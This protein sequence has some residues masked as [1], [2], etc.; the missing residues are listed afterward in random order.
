M[1]NPNNPNNNKPLINGRPADDRRTTSRAPSGPGQQLGGEASASNPQEAAEQRARESNLQRQKRLEERA[2][3]ERIEKE[4]AAREEAER[5]AKRAKAAEAAQKKRIEEAVE[6]RRQVRDSWDKSPSR[7]RS[8]QPPPP[9]AGIHERMAEEANRRVPVKKRTEKKPTSPN[10]PEIID[11]YDE[12]EELQKALAASLGDSQIQ[13]PVPPLI[14]VDSD[15]EKFYEDDED[16][17]KALMMSAAEPQKTQPTTTSSTTQST[18]IT[19]STHT[20]SHNPPHVT[21]STHAPPSKIYDVDGDVDMDLGDDPELQAALM[22]SLDAKSPTNAQG[23]LPDKE[24]DRRARIFGDSTSTSTQTSRAPRKWV[25]GLEEEEEGYGEENDPE[26]QDAL[27]LSRQVID[28]DQ[29]EG[30]KGGGGGEGRGD[31]TKVYGG[32]VEDYPSPTNGP[33]ITSIDEEEGGGGGGEEG[34]VEG[35]EDEDQELQ[36]ALMSSLNPNAS[37]AQPRRTNA[38]ARVTQRTPSRTY[39]PPDPVVASARKL[40]TEQD[41]AYEQSLAEDREKER[42]AKEAEE[43]E[44]RK[45]EEE[46]KAAKQKEMDETNR[47]EL[48]DKASTLL[49][50]EPKEGQ[51]ITIGI[52]MPNGTRFMRRFNPTDTLQDLRH[53]IESKANESNL[54]QNYEITSD[55]PKRTFHDLPVSNTLTEAGISGRMLLNLLEV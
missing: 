15:E 14:S 38:P 53:F 9:G 36:R 3:K 44:R 47:R 13:D 26:L 35:L 12:D 49:P 10:S 40:R 33:K 52:R 39:T 32:T 2:E 23:L 18:S 41:R 22:H 55:F 50:P 6:R 19:Q 45:K 17:Q 1:Y 27:M 20:T 21:T 42:K 24:R 5:V 31:R 11:V 29:D 54:S 46:G 37:P 30:G 34:R 16:L 8:H 51:G 28:V 25:Y 7:S 43:L 48:R 4:R